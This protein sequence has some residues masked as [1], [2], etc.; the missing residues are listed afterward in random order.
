MNDLPSRE[1]VQGDFID[2]GARSGPV[3][4]VVQAYTSGRLVDREAINYEAAIELARTFRNLEWN[5][6]AVRT[7]VNAALG[8]ET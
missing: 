4:D 1:A 2:L 6:R 3:C 8:E 5:H 7:V